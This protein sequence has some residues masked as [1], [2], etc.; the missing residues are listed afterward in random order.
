MSN[1]TN[2]SFNVLSIVSLVTSL[3]GLAF[4]ASIFGHIALRQIKRTGEKGYYLALIGLSLGYA[5]TLIFL[6]IL[7]LF[8][9][10]NLWA[11]YYCPPGATHIGCY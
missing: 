6:G 3:L 11:G 9:L 8:G 5:E 1:Q 7:A 2:N 10:L 4:I